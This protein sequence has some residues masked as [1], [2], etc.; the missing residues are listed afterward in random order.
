MRIILILIFLYFRAYAE[1][2]S[3]SE[4]YHE[5]LDKLIEQVPE[6]RQ[7]KDKYIEYIE[8]D[9]K[10]IDAKNQLVEQVP[11]VRRLRDKMNKA[12]DEYIKIRSFYIK[13]LQDFYGIPNL[14]Y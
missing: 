8:A 12:R 7:R 4:K 5:F 9:N 2:N 1:Q 3:Y 14:Y 10:Y 13:F 6:N 11:E